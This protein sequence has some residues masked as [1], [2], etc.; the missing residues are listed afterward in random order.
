MKKMKA[1]AE[2]KHTDLPLTSVP[3]SDDQLT[4]R[5]IGG[6]LPLPTTLFQ[7]IEEGFTVIEWDGK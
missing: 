1:M 3:L 7:V 2:A 6:T 5:G 4:T